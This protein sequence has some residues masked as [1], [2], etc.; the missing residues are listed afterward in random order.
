M[1]IETAK[2]NRTF[3]FGD[4]IKPLELVKFLVTIG[5]VK[6]VRAYIEADIVK[7][8]LPLLSPK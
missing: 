8:G 7:T 4:A 2:T 3:C 1:I 6:G 5:D